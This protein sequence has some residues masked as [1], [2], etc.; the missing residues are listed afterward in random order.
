MEEQHL[1]NVC[2]TI[3]WTKSQIEEYLILP[4]TLRKHFCFGFKIIVRENKKQSKLR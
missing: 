2:D 4:V 1:R 3:H